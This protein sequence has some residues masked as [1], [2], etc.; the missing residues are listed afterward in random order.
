MNDWHITVIS[1]SKEHLDEIVRGIGDFVPETKISL[2]EDALENIGTPPDNKGVQE[3]LAV[4]CGEGKL[5][6][7]EPV[8]RLIKI[9]RNITFVLFCDRPSSDF[10]MQAMRSGVREVLPFPVDAEAIRDALTRIR[11][12]SIMDSSKNGKVLAFMSCKG[13][14]GATFLATNL[15]YELACVENAKVA[16][17]DLNLQFGD[18][19]LFLTSKLATSSIAD[20]AENIHRLDQ[21]L[22]LSSMVEV[23]PNLC[24]LAAPENPSSAQDVTSEDVDTLIRLA[25]T[26]FDYIIVDTGRALNALT[27]KALD[28]ADTIYPILQLTLPYVRDCKRLTEAFS[29]LD[30][31]RSKIKYVINRFNKNSDIQTHHIEESLGIKVFFTIPNH[32]EGVAASVNQGIP[33]VKLSP[34]NV[35]AKALHEWAMILTTQATQPADTQA[36]GWVARTLKRIL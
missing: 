7:L 16:I 24:V 12:K 5:S 3:I 23:I 35:V 36:E 1:P 33:I 9:Y 11:S 17:F 14:S 15:A 13:G 21:R 20:V 8:E 10:L 30:Y 34:N 6:A 2:I 31:P 19:L 4:D 25:R 29:H 27:I 26:Q 32:F 18:A 22:L 28:L